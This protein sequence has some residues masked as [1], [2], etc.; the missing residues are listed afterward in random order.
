MAKNP[1]T[2][3]DV[4]NPTPDTEGKG[5]T[6][7]RAQRT[8]SFYFDA[9]GDETKD[10]R[11]AAGVQI[12]VLDSGGDPL[13]VVFDDLPAPVQNAGMAFGIQT[14]L[15]NGLGGI[16]KSDGPGE[17]LERM[18]TIFETLGNGEW[19]DRKPGEGGPRI[20]LLVEAAVNLYGKSDAEM[21]EKIAAMD[22]D[23]RKRFAANSKIDSEVKRLQAIRAQERAD[24]AREAAGEESLPELG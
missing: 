18:L 14:K 13:R 19:S 7:K 10:V 24:K 17:G 20:S 1:T 6:T 16:I 11:E 23:S 22:E 5:D 4:G 9:N 2:T 3:P 15:T 8:R 21:R 12:E